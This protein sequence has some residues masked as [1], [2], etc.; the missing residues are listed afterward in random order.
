MFQRITIEPLARVPRNHGRDGIP[1]VWYDSSHALPAGEKWVP[2]EEKPVPGENQRLEIE[3]TTEKDG[4]KVIDLTPEEIRARDVPAS[5]TR[6]QLFIA[7]FSIHSITEAQI[8]AMLQG[9][10]LGMIEFRHATAF[11]RDH[12]LISS[13]GAALGLTEEQ[14]DELFKT[15]ASL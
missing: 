9:N 2:I 13:L 15:A 14:I 7:L 11:E 12:P 3:L 1:S 8:E 6:R 10:D 4:W 5:V